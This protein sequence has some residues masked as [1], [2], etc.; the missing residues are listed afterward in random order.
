MSVLGFESVSPKSES[1]PIQPHI[2]DKLETDYK[3]IY[4]L[5]DNDKA[6]NTPGQ[7]LNNNGS[8]LLTWE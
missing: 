7:V 4:V 1:T 2:L 3:R 6:G 8:A 5:F